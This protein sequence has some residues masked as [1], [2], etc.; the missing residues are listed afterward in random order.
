VTLDAGASTTLRFTLRQS[1]L[2]I[3]DAVT[4]QPSTVDGT[5]QVYVASSSSDVR[6][7]APLRV[8]L[9]LGAQ[10]V[11]VTAPSLAD[12]GTTVQVTGAVRNT[13][14]LPIAN[15]RVSLAVPDGWT[16][17]P[18]APQRVILVRPHG[19]AKLSWTVTVSA[20]AAAGAQ[21]LSA[22]ATWSGGARSSAD[23][24]TTVNVPYASLAAAYNGAGISDDANPAGGNFDGSGY[25]YSAQALA[26]IGLTPGATA[27]YGGL[28]YHWPDAAAGAPD[29]VTAAGQTIALSG[30]GSTL[31]LLGA[32]NNGSASGTAIVTYTDGTTTSGTVT[33]AD[34]Y[35]NA[36]VPGCTLAATVPYWNRPP[37]GLPVRPIGL[38]ATTVPLD[39]GKTVAAV[40]LPNESRFHVFAAAIG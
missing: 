7:H 2:A 21:T 24:T 14:D 36:A 34:W 26:T 4:H 23:A 12:A 15:A 9:T 17:A 35:D 28:S 5:Y 29:M 25:S 11:D 16:V 33:F 37:G 30:Q 20:G 31:G 22:H 19:T 40:T 38:Y 39:P 27:T 1:D 6:T 8:P 3:W 32:G 10:S 18:A 13:G